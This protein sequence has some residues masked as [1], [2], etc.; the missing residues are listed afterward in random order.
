MR[1]I[2]LILFVTISFLSI[3]CVPKYEEYGLK[4]FENPG[5]ISNSFI[6]FGLI[7][8]FTAIILL[9]AKLNVNV[10]KLL[11]YLLIFIS[12][13]HVLLPF[14]GDY[15]LFLSLIIVA[16]LIKKPHWIIINISALLLAV[17]I[18]SMFGISLEPLPVIVLL[19]V[20]A[21][22]DWIAVH[23]T[24]HMVD[25]ADSVIKMKLP[26]LFIIPSKPKPMLLGVGDVVIPNL[27][28]VSAQTFMNTPTIGFIKIPALTALVGGLIGM[29]M[30]ITLTDRGPQAGLPFLNG[31]VIL[32][33]VIG[34]V[35]LGWI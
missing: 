1:W 3:L 18:T 6:Y 31:G 21:I 28:V 29:L 19:I 20:L 25:L 13:Y 33:F 34:I 32:G 26:L 23:K 8:I 7:L 22:Y 35:S 4:V 2:F 24:G 14:L 10:L 5:D 27:L 17:G 30:L 11:L 15:S 12:A 16:L 9:L